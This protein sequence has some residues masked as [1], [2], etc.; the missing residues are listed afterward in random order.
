MSSQ[1]PIKYKNSF[2]CVRKVVQEEG[3]RALYKGLSASYLGIQLVDGLINSL[4]SS[5]E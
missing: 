1:V 5:H 2:D 3:V 4:V